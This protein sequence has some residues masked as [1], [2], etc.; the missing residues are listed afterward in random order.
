MHAR[1]TPFLAANKNINAPARHAAAIFLIRFDIL[2]EAAA[3][4]AALLY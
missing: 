2:R 1:L 4:F 3:R